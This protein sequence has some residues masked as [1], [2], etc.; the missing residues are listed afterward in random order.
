MENILEQL[1]KDIQGYLPNKRLSDLTPGNY[2]VTDLR[3]ANS[4]YGN[5]VVAELN[6]EFNI[7][8]PMKV[9]KRLLANNK[10]VLNDMH[11]QALSGSLNLTYVGGPGFSMSFFITGNE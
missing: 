10:A 3:E 4:R 7:W 11:P 5:K 2:K 6:N 8:L 9:S 1:N